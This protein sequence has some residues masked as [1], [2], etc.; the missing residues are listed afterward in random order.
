MFGLSNS[1][2]YAILA[3]SCLEKNKGG[4]ILAKEIGD[5]TTIPRPYL[6][7]ILRVLLRAGLIQTKRGYRGGF[8]LKKPAAQISLW[9]IAK[10]ID[11]SEFLNRCMLGLADCRDER[12][13]PTHEFWSEERPKIERVL[14]ETTLADIAEFEWKWRYGKRGAARPLRG[15][16]R[17][18]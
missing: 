9:Q 10:V 6:L 2:G 16:R 11:G 7:K 3:L 12:A 4:W 15:G 17:H 13:C 18:R 1:A 5:T 14:R 8:Q